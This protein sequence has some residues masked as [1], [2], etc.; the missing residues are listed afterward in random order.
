V[1]RVIK[2]ISTCVG[3]AAS[4]GFAT[5]TAPAD[6]HH[7]L[8]MYDGTKTLV[9]TGVVTRVSPGASHV[10]ILSAPLNEERKAVLRDSKGDPVIWSLEL[11]AAAQAAREGITVTTFPAGTIFSAALHPLRSGDGGGSREGAIFKCPENTPPAPG[12]HC[13][14]VAG[15]TTHGTG[16]LPK[17][18]E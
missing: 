16:E 13:D 2:S 3:L 7:S 18:P 12:M 14:S 6:A 1:A 4:I 8:A 11:T 10:V 5:M 9:F 17:P 15:S